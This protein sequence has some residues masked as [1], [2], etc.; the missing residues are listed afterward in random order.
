MEGM[1]NRAVS[2]E[3]QAQSRLNWLRSPTLRGSD[4]LMVGGFEKNTIPNY[5]QFPFQES[6]HFESFFN[7]LLSFKTRGAGKVY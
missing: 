6:F 4:P 5:V 3:L 2:S 1:K 7:S